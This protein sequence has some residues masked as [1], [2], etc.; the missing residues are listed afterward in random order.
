MNLIPFQ[1]SSHPQ[2]SFTIGS[3]DSFER[4]LENAQSDLGIDP[5][6]AVPVLYATESKA[7]FVTCYWSICIGSHDD[8]NCRDIAINLIPSLLMLGVVIWGTM[9]MRQGLSS[10]GG[11]VCDLGSFRTIAAIALRSL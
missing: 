8:A 1:G 3:V 5:S 9:K 2:A 6:E 4:N 10:A 11:K 7:V